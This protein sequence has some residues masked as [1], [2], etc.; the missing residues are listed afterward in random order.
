[1]ALI[2]P[3]EIIVVPKKLISNIPFSKN[4]AGIVTDENV[5]E[6]YKL[7]SKNKKKISTICNLETLE[8]HNVMNGDL[9]TLQLNEGVIYMGQIEDND[10]VLDKY[11]YV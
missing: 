8:N 3:G 5:D 6:C 7:F 2:S 11:K 10:E 4:I 9:I 1:M